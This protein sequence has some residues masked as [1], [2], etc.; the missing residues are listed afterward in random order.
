MVSL[1]PLP[2]GMP[3]LSVT[4]FSYLELRNESEPDPG[5]IHRVI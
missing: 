5:F 3:V 4:P 1:F 2:P